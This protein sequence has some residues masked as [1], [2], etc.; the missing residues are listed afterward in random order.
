MVR[1][2]L[3]LQNPINHTFIQLR[4]VTE[5]KHQK[6]AGQ[7]ILMT[8]NGKHCCRGRLQKWSYPKI[9]CIYTNACWH[10]SLCKCYHWKCG[11]VNSEGIWPF[12]VLTHLVWVVNGPSITVGKI[13]V[14]L[15]VLAKM[16]VRQ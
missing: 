8:G 6:H 15:V 11:D 3:V 10:C 7:W 12:A 4:S 2:K 9:C 13:T 14:M 1:R 16:L 5:G